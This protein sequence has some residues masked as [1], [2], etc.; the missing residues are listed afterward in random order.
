MSLLASGTT[1]KAE[2]F[3]SHSAISG[4]QP[5]NKD[6][7]VDY[8]RR[9]LSDHNIDAPEIEK[10]VALVYSFKLCHGRARFIAYILDSFLASRDMELAIGEF[11]SGLSN[12][13]GDLFPLRLFRRDLEEQNTSFTNVL[14]G[15]TLGR[16]VRDGIVEYMMTGKAILLLKGQL[17]SDAVRYGLGFCKISEG[18]IYAIEMVERCYCRMLALLGSVFGC[19]R[20]IS[21]A[22]ACVTQSRRW[23]G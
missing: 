10:F 14:G 12:I 13:H 5:L 8:S 17:A 1:M 23:M 3:T 11:V 16:I 18:V 20:N 15:D 22:T 2:Q 4:I 6:A 9:I 21:I 19:G 7:I